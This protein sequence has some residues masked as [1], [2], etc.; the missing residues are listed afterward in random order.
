MCA[1]GKRWGRSSSCAARRL[2][3]GGGGRREG[4]CRMTDVGQDSTMP[5]LG[6]KL[7]RESKGEWSMAGTCHIHVPHAATQQKCTCKSRKQDET[8]RVMEAH[9]G[10]RTGMHAGA[11]LRQANPPWHSPSVRRHQAG[12]VHSRFVEVVLTK[13]LRPLWLS[14]AHAPKS[15]RNNAVTHA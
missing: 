15:V 7:V 9:S 8:H 5:H 1:S 6:R 14:A 13:Y 11:P 2:G 12:V 4:W 3:K 10:R